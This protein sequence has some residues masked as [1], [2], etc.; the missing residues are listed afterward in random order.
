MCEV[1]VEFVESADVDRVLGSMAGSA[2][3]ARVC[4]GY[5][6]EVM[7]FSLLGVLMSTVC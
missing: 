4:S 1:C 5:A 6:I 2:A 7:W 3:I